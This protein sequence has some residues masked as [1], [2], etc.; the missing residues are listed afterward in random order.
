MDGPEQKQFPAFKGNYRDYSTGERS[1]FAVP[2]LSECG[3]HDKPINL[4]SP[5]IHSA[6][7]QKY[8]GLV[9]KEALE[10]KGIMYDKNIKTAIVY[11]EHP[12]VGVVLANKDLLQ[13]DNE[14]F[15]PGE[16]PNHSS[17]EKVPVY[18]IDMNLT[19]ACL[20]VLVEDIQ[21]NLPLL[22]LKGLRMKVSRPGVLDTKFADTKEMVTESD[23]LMLNHI[24]NADNSPQYTQTNIKR[25]LHVV[26][27]IT[28]AFLG[29]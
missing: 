19:R 26:V 9:S 4:T 14:Q 8:R 15:R 5:F 21:H 20:D 11:A 1:H 7:I 22:N 18:Y 28:Y 6:Y 23:I 13:I 24:K 29:E 2:P 17:G 27:A 12:L 25:S 16:I 10:N 3:N